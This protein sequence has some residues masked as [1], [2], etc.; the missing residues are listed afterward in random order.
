[1]D[2][3]R[4]EEDEGTSSDAE[5]RD[6]GGERVRSTGEEK[7]EIG[8]LYGRGIDMICVVLWREE[9][10][11]RVE[12]ESEGAAGLF[13]AESE[14]RE[15]L[16]ASVERI[17]TGDL[18]RLARGA[19]DEEPV[20]SSWAAAWLRE[21]D[22]WSSAAPVFLGGTSEHLTCLSLQEMQRPPGSAVA[23][24]SQAFL[25][26][27]QASHYGRVS[28]NGYNKKKKGTYWDGIRD[29]GHLVLRRRYT[30]RPR[31]S[32]SLCLGGCR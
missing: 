19:E 1:V 27:L 6:A 17:E 26:F 8:L 5:Y 22:P 12:D 2:G 7:E 13:L 32:D 29:H 21:D 11:S 25:D 9:R 24:F 18:E 30:T 31:H 4:R 28:R 16:L 3:A 20:G 23:F 14:W 10:G 15:S